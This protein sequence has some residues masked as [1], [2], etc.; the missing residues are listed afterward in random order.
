MSINMNMTSPFSGFLFYLKFILFW[1]LPNTYPLKNDMQAV[2]L[3]QY[4]IQ[5]RKKDGDDRADIF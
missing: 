2:C 5:F 1:S 3:H 4:V